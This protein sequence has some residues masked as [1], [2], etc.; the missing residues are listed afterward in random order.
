MYKKAIHKF[1]LMG[2]NDVYS[3]RHIVSSKREREREK[4]RIYI[5]FMR[6]STIMINSFLPPYHIQIYSQ[7]FSYMPYHITPSNAC[8]SWGMKWFFVLFFCVFRFVVFHIDEIESKVL[9]CN[10]NKYFEITAFI[11]NLII[12]KQSVRMCKENWICNTKVW[13]LDFLNQLEKVFFFQNQGW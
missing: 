10:R 6:Q 11:S 8:K 5:F 4:K 12:C 9:K 1:M 2:K 13:K 7:T 3:R